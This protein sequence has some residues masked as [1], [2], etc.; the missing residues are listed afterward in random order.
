[1]WSGGGFGFEGCS[2]VVGGLLIIWGVFALL[3]DVQVFVKR[4][5]LEFRL[6]K[7]TEKDSDRI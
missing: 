2:T 6:S 5:L 1:M 4:I 7:S 3:L